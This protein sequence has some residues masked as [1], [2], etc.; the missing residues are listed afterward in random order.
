ML[1][2]IILLS[3]LLVGVLLFTII[4]CY[5]RDTYIRVYDENGKEIEHLTELYNYHKLDV[6]KLKVARVIH[7]T[8]YYP[9]RYITKKKLAW[10]DSETIRFF[11]G[12]FITCLSLFALAICG[13]VGICRNNSIVKAQTTMAYQVRIEDLEDREQTIRNCLKGEY[14]IQYTIQDGTYRIILDQ[15]L[16]MKKSIDEYN[17]EV[18]E[19]KQDI[20]TRKIHLQSPWLNWFTTPIENLDEYNPDARNYKEVLGDSLKIFEIVY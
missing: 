9:C 7:G 2:V 19:L 16:E 17:K 18:R 5:T 12:V 13:V 15:P 4:N 20:Y 1:F 8:K 11:V 3:L 10:E 14:Q 6:D